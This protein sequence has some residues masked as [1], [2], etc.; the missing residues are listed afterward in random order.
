MLFFLN[1][2]KGDLT[3]FNYIFF[4]LEQLGTEFNT[5][6]CSITG[7]VLFLEIQRGKEAEKNR[8]YHR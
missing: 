4:N 6:S 3:H 1:K 8:K 5:V 7:A 2:E